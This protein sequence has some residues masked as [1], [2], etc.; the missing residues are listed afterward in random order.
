MTMTSFLR[1]IF[2][3]KRPPIEGAR[4]ILIVDDDESL[5]DS[6]K[7]ILEGEGYEILLASTR[8]KATELARDALPSVAIVDLK[9]P[10]GSGTALLSELNSVAPGI[11]CI[12]MTAYADVDSA[13]LAIEKG[14]FYYLRKPVDP[15]EL[16]ELVDL[17]FETIR[18][19]DEKQKAEEA[20]K[21]RNRELEETVERLQKLTG[22]GGSQ[23]TP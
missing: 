2:P 6:L 4:R 20:L 21:S 9:L 19:K 10:D 23:K 17:A 13:V 8:A 5:S 14:A 1:K 15:P 3:N 22:T 18:L 16:V 12:L 7:D 11:T